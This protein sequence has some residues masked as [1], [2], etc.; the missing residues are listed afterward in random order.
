MRRSVRDWLLARAPLFAA[1][2]AFVIGQ[3]CVA[4]RLPGRDFQRFVAFLGADDGVLVE[5]ES[6]RWEPSDG[7][8]V[9]LT[10]GRRLLFLGRE[11]DAESNDVFRGRVRLS[12]DGQPLAVSALE[13]LTQTPQ[14]DERG[15][16]LDGSRAS[17]VAFTHG[18]ARGLT[19]LELDGADSPDLP[20]NWLNR[21]LLH[22][23]GWQEADSMFGIGRTHL[24]FAPVSSLSFEWQ[25]EQLRI[26]RPRAPMIRY[27]ASKRG[28]V[29]ESKGV[30]VVPQPLGG[31][32]W[33][34]TLADLL[35]E[36][37]GS[38]SV[39]RLTAWWFDAED[40][41][42]RA[43]TGFTPRSEVPRPNSTNEDAQGLETGTW[44]PRALAPLGNG[45][46]V[47]EGVWRA[48]SSELAR[49]NVGE[50][51]FNTTFLLPDPQRPDARLFLVAMDMRRLELG[52]EA[53]YEDP[54][55]KTGLP[56][57]GSLSFDPSVVRRVRATFNGAFKSLHGDYGMTVDERV[58]VPPVARAA[59]VAVT[60]SGRIGFG[61]WPPPDAVK[62]QIVSLRQ[63]LD[64]LVQA[65]T[66]NPHNR[67]EW[68]EHPL[69]Q[70]I[71]TE[72]SALCLRD[73][74]HL[75][76]AWGEAISAPTLATGL[77]H[78]GC[79][80][81]IHLDMNPRHC[82]FFFHDSPDGVLAN[83]R[84][85]SAFPGVDIAPTRFARWSSKD[86]FYVLARDPGTDGGWLPDPGA[87]PASDWVPA[88]TKGVRPVG[89][90]SLDVI[91]FARGPL[92][93][94]ILSGSAEPILPGRA[95]P[96]RK[97]APGKTALFA[98]NLGHTTKSTSYGLAFSAESSIALDHRYATLV[99][100]EDGLELRPPG[101]SVQLASGERAVQLPLL[102]SGGELLER[103]GEP[104]SLRTRAG[105]CLAEDGAVYVASM[106]H[107]TSASIAI[108]LR[109]LGCRDAVELDRGSQDNAFIHRAGTL[110]GVRA[111]YTTSVLV[112]VEASLE[113]RTFE[114]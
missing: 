51:L 32:Y 78:A 38:E 35:R 16:Y 11:S 54:R 18:E 104:G 98:I 57:R 74:G 68:G 97:L 111:E 40:D 80:F 7:W 56:G 5:A 107:D 62:E 95:A 43:S 49:A 70:G 2:G 46:S 42:K 89:E 94:E 113:A 102:M 41:I 92:A 27:D 59:T 103:A 105:L 4:E 20:G 64:P 67:T 106:R 53:G 33:M 69:L 34:H 39:M 55:P 88:I 75:M 15:L 85:E 109:E 24:H 110:D 84:G 12:R 91:R 114:W 45:I 81:A 72:R 21:A 10:F 79:R 90:L 36:E 23:R 19:V 71:L 112:G 6:L 22:L 52:M 86:F 101:S 60:A 47:G 63:N 66:I 28:L 37:L 96:R 17:Y 9:D 26:E 83:L 31:D 30:S 44:P 100:G 93:F 65:G 108:G 48:P 58:L 13:N 1:V 82:G 8:L 14:G 73:D 87:Q 61:A 3:T 76:Y 77:A 25:A 99:I 29:A 50:P